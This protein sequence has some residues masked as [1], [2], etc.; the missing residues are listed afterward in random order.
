MAFI[1]STPARAQ[2]RAELLISVIALF[3]SG[4]QRNS[5]GASGKA[6]RKAD[7]HPAHIAKKT[8]TDP[9]IDCGDADGGHHG[10]GQLVCGF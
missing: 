1:E 6:T 8:D 2:L 10:A 4:G 7:I 5:G 9:A 3:G